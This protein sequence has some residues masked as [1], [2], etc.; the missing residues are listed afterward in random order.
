MVQC[1]IDR[2]ALVNIVTEVV[3]NFGLLMHEHFSYH[4]A[5]LGRARQQPCI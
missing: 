1:L 2:H 5:Q 3:V 4:F